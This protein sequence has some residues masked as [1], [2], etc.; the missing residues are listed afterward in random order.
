MLCLWPVEMGG[1]GK[2]RQAGGRRRAG[3]AGGV[4]LGRVARTLPPPSVCRGA[5]ARGSA[6]R[7][8]GMAAGAASGGGAA[9]ATAT[10]RVAPR[11]VRA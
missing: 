6:R 1:V 11:G 3:A 4:R 8:G 7:G 2:D 5:A 10:G 9:T